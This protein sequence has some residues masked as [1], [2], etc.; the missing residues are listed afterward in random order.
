MTPPWPAQAALLE[1]TDVA[2]TGAPPGTGN[3]TTPGRTTSP[4]SPSGQPDSAYVPKD[5]FD[6]EIFNRRYFGR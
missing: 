3:N 5:P 1:S 4:N 2:A 6:P